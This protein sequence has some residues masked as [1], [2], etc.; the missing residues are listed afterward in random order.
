MTLSQWVSYLD[1]FFLSEI[2]VEIGIKMFEIQQGIFWEY[3]QNFQWLPTYGF[4]HVK[5]KK[6]IFLSLILEFIGDIGVI[7][8][9][10]QSCYLW[11]I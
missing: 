5:L 8:N 11:T 7:F 1:A 2:T 10:F 6:S 9:N 4:A 3:S